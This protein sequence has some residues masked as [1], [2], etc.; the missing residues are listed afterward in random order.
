MAGRRPGRWSW[1]ESCRWYTGLLSPWPGITCHHS[2]PGGAAIPGATQHLSNP[3]QCHIQPQMKAHFPKCPLTFHVGPKIVPTIDGI[4]AAPRG[5]EQ[6][7]GGKWP[8]VSSSSAVSRPGMPGHLD[9][10]TPGQL[11]TWTL[12]AR[13][14]GLLDTWTPRHLGTWTHRHQVT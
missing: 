4:A 14:P 3:R 6:E 5:G 9:T 11:G 2:T 12:N 7:S 10:W 13:S 1:G 8:L